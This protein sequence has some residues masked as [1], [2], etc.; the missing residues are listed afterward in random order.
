M[1]S[2]GSSCSFGSVSGDRL[3]QARTGKSV[4]GIRGG[5]A[6]MRCN[7]ME[8]GIRRI[9]PAA[10]GLSHGAWFL[11]GMLAGSGFSETRILRAG[12]DHRVMCTG[13]PQRS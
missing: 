13:R 9:V 3:A 6:G 8:T 12:L 10:E 4:F 5:L 2:G 1:S 11:E 7:P